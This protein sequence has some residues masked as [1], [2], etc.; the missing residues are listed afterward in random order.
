MDASHI[1]VAR[2]GGLLVSLALLAAPVLMAPR[3]HAAVSIKKAELRSGSLLVE[4][5]GAV[6]GAGITITSPESTATGRADSRGEFK[7]SASGYRSST[8]RATVTDGS[9]SA[10]ATL[11]DCT[12]SA[13]PTAPPPPPPPA[14]SPPP[15]TTAVITPDV[16]A[17]GPGFVGSDFTSTSATTTTMTLTPNALGPV[18]FEIVAGRL[19]TGLRLVDPNAGFTPAKSIHASVAGVPTTVETTTFTIRATD[20]NGLRA[21]RTYSI[22]INPAVGL[23]I[24]PQPWAPLTVGAFGNLWIDGSGGVRPYRWARAAGVFPPGMRLIQDNP[25][26]PLVRLG[27]TPTT[28]GTF[29][30]T[31]RLRDAR[32]AST[33]RTFTVTVT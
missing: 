1:R 14:P 33:S 5:Q 23:A 20:A 10:T 29:T 18:R 22:R 30:F 4:G 28:A 19:P 32:D 21:S 15:A 6:G 9:T 7:V 16:A 8:C 17:L 13:P 27:G 24:T 2:A 3:A 11:A 25:S 26:G 12:V 31:I